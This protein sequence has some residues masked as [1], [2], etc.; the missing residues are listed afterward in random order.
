M[1]RNKSK[2]TWSKQR[3]LKEQQVQYD[4]DWCRV[5]G[6]DTRPPTSFCKGCDAK[7]EKCCCLADEMCRAIPIVDAVVN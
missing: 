6:F 1:R 4:T 3:K 7:G 5:N 2:R